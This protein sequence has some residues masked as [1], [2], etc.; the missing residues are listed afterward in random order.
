MDDLEIVQLYWERDEKAIVETEEKYH[1]YL[2]KI[3]YN[4]LS[5]H[6]DTKE[7]INDTYIKIW[8]SIPPQKPTSFYAYIGRVIRNLSIDLW[9]KN[10]AKKRYVGGDILLSELEDCIPSSSS[11]WQEV[12]G[13]ILSRILSDWLYTLPKEERVMFVQRYWYGDSIKEIARRSGT[14]PKKL[15]SKMFR[16]RSNLKGVLGNE[17]IRV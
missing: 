5:N 13:K 15:A 10:R 4:I 9:Q 17:E 14:N 2:Y 11:V 12:E 6:E 7:C 16:L 8:N 1:R 3:S